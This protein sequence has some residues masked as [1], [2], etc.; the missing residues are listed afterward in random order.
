MRTPAPT[1]ETDPGTLVRTTQAQEWNRS[2]GNFCKPRAQWPDEGIGPYK[3][4]SIIAPSSGLSGAAFSPGGRL[5]WG[6]PSFA[7]GKD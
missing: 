1:A 4:R 2:S 7:G 6:N 3:K 5:F